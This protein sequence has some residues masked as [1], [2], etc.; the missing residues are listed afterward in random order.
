[1]EITGQGIKPENLTGDELFNIRLNGDD[2]IAE[3][4]RKAKDGG[5]FK[6]YTLFLSDVL[7]KED[8]ELRFLFAKHFNPLIKQWGKKSE[9]WEG[10]TIQI[11]PR[12]MGKFWDLDLL[13]VASHLDEEKV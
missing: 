3:E 4:K 10:N 11:K 8:K 7:T 1:M 6:Q 5:A 13:P 9:S 2:C 12:Q